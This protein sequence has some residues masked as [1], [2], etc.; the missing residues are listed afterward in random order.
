MLPVALSR[1]HLLDID[2]FLFSTLAAILI[3]VAWSYLM[4]KSSR[5]TDAKM[6]DGHPSSVRD[7]VSN[8]DEK[9]QHVASL[10]AYAQSHWETNPTNALTAILEATAMNSGKESADL[11]MDRI[12]SE[13]GDGVANHI[14]D[15]QGRKERAVQAVRDMV[16]DDS[17]VLAEGGRQDIL[18]Q[19]MEDGS[20]VM[21]TRCQGLVPASRWQQHQ[22]FWCNANDSD[23]GNAEQS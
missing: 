22:Q 19:A 6:A 8:G 9:S 15:V 14:E 7:R 11:A 1:D 16:E 3:P 17:T 10:I 20:S 4:K 18:R 5:R 12:R 21:C 13:L 2:I 23:E